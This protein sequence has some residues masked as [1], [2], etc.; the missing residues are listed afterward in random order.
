MKINFNKQN[1][2]ANKYSNILKKTKEIFS[3][4]VIINHHIN[5]RKNYDINIIFSYFR[6]INKKIFGDQ[7]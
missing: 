6:V 3:K 4:I 2:W 1:S 7:I 5:L